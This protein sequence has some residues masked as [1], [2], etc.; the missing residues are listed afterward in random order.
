MMIF[1]GG[2]V[3]SLTHSV[4]QSAVRGQEHQARWHCH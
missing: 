1:K 3:L 4:S 2:S